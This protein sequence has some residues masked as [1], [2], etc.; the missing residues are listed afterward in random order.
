MKAL[1]G[2]QKVKNFAKALGVVLKTYYRYESGERKVPDGILKLAYII[3]GKNKTV[4]GPLEGHKEHQAPSDPIDQIMLG[5]AQLFKDQNKKIADLHN[6]C[7]DILERISAHEK[8]GHTG[9]A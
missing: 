4:Q 7:E 3:T 6:I 8:K 2:S 5:F 9:N 1:R